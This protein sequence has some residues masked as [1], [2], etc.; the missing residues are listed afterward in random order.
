MGIRASGEDSLLDSEMIREFPD[1]VDEIRSYSE[2]NYCLNA[3]QFDFLG[4]A[5]ILGQIFAKQIHIYASKLDK[6][7]DISADLDFHLIN[8]LL[9]L[10]TLHPQVIAREMYNFVSIFGEKLNLICQTFEFLTDTQNTYQQKLIELKD[11]TTQLINQLKLIVSIKITGKRSSLQMKANDERVL[12]PIK[13]LKLFISNLENYAGSTLSSMIP[14]TPNILKKY[15]FEINGIKRDSNGETILENWIFTMYKDMFSTLRIESGESHR[16]LEINYKMFGGEYRSAS[17]ARIISDTEVISEDKYEELVSRLR[18]LRETSHPTHHDKILNL[19]NSIQDRVKELNSNNI[20]DLLNCLKK[21]P[22]FYKSE[23][24]TL[25]EQF[26]AKSKWRNN[27]I[28]FDDYLSI[29][30]KPATKKSTKGVDSLKS[31]VDKTE[32]LDYENLHLHISSAISEHRIAVDEYDAAK[33]NLQSRLRDPLFKDKVSIQ[34]RTLNKALE[35]LRT[36]YKKAKGKLLHKDKRAT[37]K[38]LHERIDQFSLD[39]STIIDIFRSEVNKVDESGMPSFSG[40]QAAMMIGLGEGGERIVRATIAKM[41]NNHTDTRC[42][43]LLSGLNIDMNKIT[44]VVKKRSP[45]TGTGNLEFDFVVS[46]SNPEDV[47]MTDLFEKA[48]ILAINAGPEQNDRL[49]EKY[50]YIWGTIGKNTAV[51]SKEGKY[52]SLST[53]T[54]LVDVNKNG[55][56][57]RMGKGRAFAVAA[58]QIIEQKLLD[59]RANQSIKQ[60]C[61]VHSFA[62][63]SGSGMILPVLRMVKRVYPTALIWVLSAAEAMHGKAKNDE[64]NVIY[65]TSDILQAHYNALH[66]TPKSIS[67]SDWQKFSTS[68]KL[69]QQDLSNEWNEIWKHFPDNEPQL[70]QYSA[71]MKNRQKSLVKMIKEEYSNIN[72][73]FNT[74][75]Y[76]DD[77]EPHVFLPG[78]DNESTSTFQDATRDPRNRGAIKKLWFAWNETMEDPGTHIITNHPKLFT[79]FTKKN[80]TTTEEDSVEFKLNYNALMTINKGIGALH[81]NG[82]NKEQAESE[83]KKSYGKMPELDYQLIMFGMSAQKLNENEDDELIELQKKIKSYGRKM[84]IYHQEL[85]DQWELIQLNLIMKND[86]LVKHIVVSNKHF[87]VN[88]SGLVKRENNYEVYNSVLADTYINIIHQLVS[89]DS[90]V[91]DDMD[92]EEEIKLKEMAG[93]SEAMD[94]SDIKRRTKPTSSTISLSLNDMIQNSGCVRYNVELDREKIRSNHVYKYVFSKLFDERTSPLFNQDIEDQPP[95]AELDSIQGLFNNLFYSENVL[96]D[97]PPYDAIEMDEYSRKKIKD[98]LSL[99]N[100]RIRDFYKEKVLK[101]LDSEQR[102]SLEQR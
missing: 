20:S 61:I 81:T 73:G 65:I 25:E 98:Y 41:L 70:A 72:F 52:D 71:E 59:K 74:T 89:K 35:S 47:N 51:G 60:I 6:N 93:S 29:T 13:S 46:T 53:N 26:D 84:R 21:P 27:I 30:K 2:N 36:D 86:S 15:D 34:N 5:T 39:C 69:K 50:N 42:S 12:M 66:H 16:P 1:L 48:N 57:G 32:G 99:Q 56:G 54:I 101:A 8:F 23:S 7:P 31:F 44:E 88:A 63:G 68:V 55:C 45:E 28:E 67:I 96:V 77:S 97:F 100:T 38:P 91:E 37:E 58:E 43:N 83:H 9:S 14:E 3:D 64:D 80:D 78:F 24:R 17:L 75:K 33:I 90:L 82:F 4:K 49:K 92:L 102:K 19:S 79:E 94:L 22:S 40:P 85:V 10:E 95:I 87:D 76:T 62:G 11:V 18:H